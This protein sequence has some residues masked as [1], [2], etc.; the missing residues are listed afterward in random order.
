MPEPTLAVR[1]GDNAQ[2]VLGT[3]SRREAR[4]CAAREIS[5][6][7]WTLRVV[8][9][10]VR[11]ISRA[12]C[13]ANDH[14]AEHCVCWCRGEDWYQLCTPVDPDARVAWRIEPRPA[15]RGWR[16]LRELPARISRGQRRDVIDRAA[17]S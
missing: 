3:A 9:A 2:W 1:R 16:A 7:R 15:A 11:P 5:A 12:Q 6:P 4:T 8:A 17:M 10:T 14:P 13:A